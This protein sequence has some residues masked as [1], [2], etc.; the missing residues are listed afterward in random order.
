MIT[1]KLIK[2][3]IFSKTVLF[4]CLLWVMAP[5]LCFSAPGF[6]NAMYHLTT[7]DSSVELN[8]T[9]PAGAVWINIGVSKAGKD[10]NAGDPNDRVFIIPV[11]PGP[12]TQKLYVSGSGTFEIDVFYATTGTRTENLAFS[13]F[14]SFWVTNTDSRDLS[15]LEPSP[16]VQ[17]DDPEILSLALS[18]TQG[19]TSD[20]E[21]SIAIHNWVATH[22]AYDAPDY[23]AQPTIIY[24]LPDALSTLHRK[25]ALCE[26]YANLNAALHRAA[27]IRAKNITGTV[28]PVVS[29]S[30]N[31]PVPAQGSSTSLPPA[32]TGSLTCVHVNHRWNE[33]LI[34]G[35]WM[36]Q[37]ATWDSGVIEPG[38]QKFS[39][40]FSTKYLYPDAHSFAA[41]HLKCEEY[42]D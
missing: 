19:L 15:F 4:A 35:E 34:G 16:D 3:Q 36:I 9:V 17:S 6:K 28:D 8:L 13:Y 5:G 14:Q 2:F 32:T 42:R 39:P 23:F 24:P 29:N 26:G 30:S 37:D 31:S 11:T 41:D 27:G 40:L 1:L 20:R 21:K 38:T 25:T 18:I 12:L 10:G 33:V 7:T 22:I